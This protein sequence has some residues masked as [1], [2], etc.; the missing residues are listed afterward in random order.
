MLNATAFE[1]ITCT[2]DTQPNANVKALESELKAESD[3]IALTPTVTNSTA[4]LIVRV[5]AER[6]TNF[7]RQAQ[8]PVAP[9]WLLSE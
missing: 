3:P 5:P 4:Q 6:S 1:A 7:L 2:A 9:A 8:Y